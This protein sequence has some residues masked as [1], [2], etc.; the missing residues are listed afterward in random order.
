MQLKLNQYAERELADDE[1]MAVEDHLQM[2]P[3]CRQQLANVRQMTA[4]LYH[5]P[6]EETP[7]G[8]EARIMAAVNAPP[9]R[10]DV[11]QTWLYRAAI[12]LAALFSL[13]MLLALGYQ[14]LLVWQQG[15][16]GQF[17]SLL[18]GNPDLAL[19]YPTEALYA[20]LESLPIVEIT[21][22]LGISLVI[23]LLLEQFL[24]T[25]GGQAPSSFNDNHVG[26]GV[27]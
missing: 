9:E 14:T 19:R 5:L 17:I 16:T 21:L 10:V 25:L 7:A 23:V 27:A 8:L 15:G 1:R 12:G 26:T 22:T 13:L 2:C 3:S 11:V 4:L 6:V 24:A 18:A 20:V